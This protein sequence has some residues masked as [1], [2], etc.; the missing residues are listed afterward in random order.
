[1]KVCG[2]QKVRVVC[3]K[4]EEKVGVPLKEMTIETMKNPTATI[5]MDSRHVKPIAMM[6]LANCHVAALFSRQRLVHPL[7]FYVVRT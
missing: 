3:G 5:A 1:M 6:P 2:N 7:L 4:E